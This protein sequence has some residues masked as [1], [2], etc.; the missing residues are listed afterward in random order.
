MGAPIGPKPQAGTGTAAPAVAQ[1]QAP[2][3][4]GIGGAVNL[5]RMMLTPG[6]AGVPFQ[7]HTLL[8]Q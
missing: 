7:L 3:S 4:G 2:G 5:A 6:A 1:M 8:G